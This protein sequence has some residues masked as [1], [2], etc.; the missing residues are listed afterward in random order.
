MKI[1]IIAAAFIGLLVTVLIFPSMHQSVNTSVTLQTA[2]QTFDVA[3]LFS[4]QALP[5]IGL[6]ILIIASLIILRRD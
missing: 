1:F 2:S 3:T 5:W 6:G 4:M